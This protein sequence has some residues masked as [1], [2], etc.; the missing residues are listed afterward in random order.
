M[1]YRL[2]RSTKKANHRTGSMQPPCG[3]A[4]LHFQSNQRSGRRTAALGARNRPTVMRPSTFAEANG[5]EGE[6]PRRKCTTAPRLCAHSALLQPA[7]QH[8]GLGPH[9]M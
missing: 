7:V 3:Y 4:P 1:S 2:A 5:R 9:I 8:G 6:P